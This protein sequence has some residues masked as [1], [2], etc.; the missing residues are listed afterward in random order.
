MEYLVNILPQFIV[1]F[2]G[3]FLSKYHNYIE[4]WSITLGLISFLLY[5]YKSTNNRI[6]MFECV[7]HLENAQINIA[8]AHNNIEGFFFIFK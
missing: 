7:S 3:G 8:Y 5:L 2:S 4:T 6:N 1:H